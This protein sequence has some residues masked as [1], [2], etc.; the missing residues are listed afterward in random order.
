MLPDELAQFIRVRYLNDE[1]QIGI[2]LLEDLSAVVP[3]HGDAVWYV[4]GGRQHRHRGRGE[5]S[6]QEDEDQSRTK[7]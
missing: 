1:R 3:F 2:N 5:Q 6:C 4:I 7:H